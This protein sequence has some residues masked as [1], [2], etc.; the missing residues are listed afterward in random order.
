VCL[1]FPRIAPFR[2][3]PQTSLNCHFGLPHS[4]RINALSTGIL[5]RQREKHN[6]T[7]AGQRVQMSTA[8]ME[9]FM[10]TFAVKPLPWFKVNPQA[11]K[12]FD[13]QELRQLGESLKVRQLQPVTAKPDGTLLTGERRLRAAQLV[14][15]PSLM[16]IITEEPLTETEIKVMQLVENVQRAELTGAER[17]QASEELLS[18]NPG[19]TQN[20]LATHLHLSPGMVTR[21]VSPSKC[22]SAVQQALLAGK[23]GITDCYAISK[24]PQDQQQEALALKLSGASRDAIEQHGRKQRNGNGTPAVRIDRV[25]FQ[26]SGSANVTVAGNELSLDDVIEKL[27]ELLKEAK[28]ANDQGLDV[29]TLARMCADRAGK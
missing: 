12:S 3:L 5:P 16:V 8:K 17:W 22:I 15:L 1:L 21:L 19:W 2:R 9:R 28:K 23:V 20:D 10:T 29:K 11:R 13:E 25:K 18:L 7:A 26:M 24:L 6:R 14:G 27:S 4:W